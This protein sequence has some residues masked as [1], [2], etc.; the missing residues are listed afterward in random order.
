MLDTFTPLA[1]GQRLSQPLH[2]PAISTHGDFACSDPEISLAW[3]FD[4]SRLSFCKAHQDYSL[5]HGT[6][7]DP[8]TELMTI[9]S[10]RWTVVPL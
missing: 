6:Y 10:D 3:R 5:S 1:E 2:R 7:E 9:D 8:R 4:G